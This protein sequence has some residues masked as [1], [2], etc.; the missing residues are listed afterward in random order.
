MASTSITPT[1]NPAPYVP[2]PDPDVPFFNKIGAYTRAVIEP[3]VSACSNCKRIAFKIRLLKGQ[4][5]KV[6][7]GKEIPQEFEAICEHALQKKFDSFAR[8]TKPSEQCR[9]C[10]ISFYEHRQAHFIE[11][12]T[13]FCYVGRQKNGK[14]RNTYVPPFDKLDEQHPINWSAPAIPTAEESDVPAPLEQLQEVPTTEELNVPAPLEQS[15]EVINETDEIISSKFEEPPVHSA[16]VEE[17]PETPIVPEPVEHSKSFW[18]SMGFWI[19]MCLLSLGMLIAFSGALSH[20]LQAG[21]ILPLAALDTTQSE[22]DYVYVTPVPEELLLTSPLSSAKGPQPTTTS[23]STPTGTFTQPADPTPSPEASRSTYD[24]IVA[25]ATFAVGT[26]QK[27]AA[28]VAGVSF[29]L[30]ALH[31]GPSIMASFTE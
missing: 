28:L 14:E 9:Y 29:V 6:L 3:S 27:V 31:F 4:V 18:N 5:A 13:K 21:P 11:K 19:T 25:T 23:T 30:G 16:E 1:T 17:I 12:I 10:N 22:W 7:H 2:F 24:T 20:I 15:Q 26:P 8:T